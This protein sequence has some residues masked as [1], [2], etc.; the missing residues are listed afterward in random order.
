LYLG[1]VQYATFQKE[2]KGL[3]HEDSVNSLACLSRLLKHVTL[4]TLL[5]TNKHTQVSKPTELIKT[6][7]MVYIDLHVYI[8]IPQHTGTTD[9]NG[10]SLSCT[11]VPNISDQIFGAD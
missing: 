7:F 4:V 6:Y 11:Q 1:H 5:C 9:Q 3:N 2:K 10:S 8:Y